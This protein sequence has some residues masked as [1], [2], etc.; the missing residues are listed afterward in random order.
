MKD[1]SQS[2]L[3]VV[4]ACPFSRHVDPVILLEKF[5]SVTGHVRVDVLLNCV[6]L[7]CFIELLLVLVHTLTSL[8][9]ISLQLLFE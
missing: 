3:R 7:S 5:G 6:I 4:K 2:E 1:L 8:G 9:L